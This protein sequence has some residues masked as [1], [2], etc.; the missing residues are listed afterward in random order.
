MY[1][2]CFVRS[3]SK[4]VREAKSR[5]VHRLNMDLQNPFLRAEDP[6]V[7]H[8]D[9]Q[10]VLAEQAIANAGQSQAMYNYNQKLLE[11]KE[12]ELMESI[13]LNYGRIREV[14][15]ELGNLQLQ[16]KLTSGPKK[17]ALEL[18]RKKIETQ[19]ERV[20]YVRAKHTAAKA[21]F[22]RLDAELKQEE[23]V[24]DQLCGE[25]NTLVQQAA[26]AQLDKLEELKV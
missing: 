17:H 25:L 2:W 19:N 20:A 26:K 1:Q 16:L 9:S 8:E 11:Q 4:A 5:E 23:A 12:R 13:A 7:G 21:T 3:A 24:K 6:G 18:L 14:E 22:D 15:R 10:E